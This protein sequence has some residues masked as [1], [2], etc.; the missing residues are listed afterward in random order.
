MQRVNLGK[1]A[2]ELY[3]AVAELDLELGDGV[4]AGGSEKVL[5][6][7][8]CQFFIQVDHAAPLKTEF[9]RRG[10]CRGRCQP[11]G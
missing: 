10:R 1:A 11:R 3:K 6:S 2:P 8:G 5:P 4:F 7:A 9:R